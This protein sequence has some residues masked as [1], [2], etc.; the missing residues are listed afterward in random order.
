MNPST[1]NTTARKHD[2]VRAIEIDD[3]DF[4]VSIEWSG[5]NPQPC[6][7]H[8]STEWQPPTPELR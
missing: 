1:E 6:H 4:Q 3:S 2:R 8:E 7:D 5:F